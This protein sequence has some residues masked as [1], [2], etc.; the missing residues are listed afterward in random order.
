MSI[1]R[2]ISSDFLF[3]TSMSAEISEIFAS[4]DAFLDSKDVSTQGIG[5]DIWKKNRYS[6]LKDK[7]TSIAEAEKA[8]TNKSKARLILEL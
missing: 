8:S 1:E 3:S 6:S 4:S 5:L 2:S 7:V